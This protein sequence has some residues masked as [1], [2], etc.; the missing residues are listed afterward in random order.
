MEEV[1]LYL[2]DYGGGTVSV[3]ASDPYAD[4]AEYDELFLGELS[5]FR[6]T[7]TYAESYASASLRDTWTIS[8]GATGSEGTLR[9]SYMLDGSLE[10]TSSSI[11]DGDISSAF[12]A[13]SSGAL[14]IGRTG[15]IAPGEIG[16]IDPGTIFNFGFNGTLDQ[17]VLLELGFIF[18]EAFDLFVGMPTYSSLISTLP[19]PERGPVEGF[20]SFANFFNTATL[21]N[22]LILDGT[23]NPIRFALETA[24]GP[25]V[26]K[27]SHPSW[28]G[29]QWRP[30]RCLP[31]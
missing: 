20:A 13:S 14:R 15:E 27:S 7:P 29:V 25:A 2:E 30:Y 8:G 26:F 3:F 6:P 12:A 18:G 11:S 9:M 16:V 21:D 10:S 5:E 1:S 28:A 24:S 17:L 19:E 22:I 4:G 31:A 23:D